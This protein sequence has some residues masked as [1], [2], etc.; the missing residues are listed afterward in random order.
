[1]TDAIVPSTYNVLSIPDTF[2]DGQGIFR[3][4][5]EVEGDE[6]LTAVYQEVVNQLREEAADIPMTTVQNLLIERIA[7]LFVIIKVHDENGTWLPR[8]Q[9][10]YNALWLSMS[11][12][13]N[14]LLLASQEVRYA[15]TMDKIRTAVI[16]A[17][18]RL[19]EPEMRSKMREFL[20]EE[21]Q[22]AGL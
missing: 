4:P 2:D 12:E 11:A 18:N 10:E 9:R 17:A 5:S 7:S 1:M 20:A 13:F 6:R 8:Q 16:A 22:K 3:L 14:K 19:P 21:F 15:A